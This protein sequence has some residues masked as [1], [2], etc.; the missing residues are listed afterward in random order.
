VVCSW[1]PPANE[2]HH[3]LIRRHPR[4]LGWA[5]GD[6]IDPKSV[7][8]L[9]HAIVIADRGHARDTAPQV[10]EPYYSVFTIA[11]SIALYGGTCLAVVAP[12]V[13]GLKLTPTKN[14]VVVRWMWPPGCTAVRV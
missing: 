3:V 7:Q 2:Q 10:A 8:Q 14:G 6:L 4:P 5:V 12:D 9:G 1:T 13:T 11:G